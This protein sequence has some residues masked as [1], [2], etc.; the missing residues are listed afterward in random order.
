MEG[1]LWESGPQE[2]P[3]PSSQLPDCPLP[4]PVPTAQHGEHVLVESGMGGAEPGRQARQTDSPPERARCWP[5]SHLAEPLRQTAAGQAS[6]LPNE[7]HTIF[8]PIFFQ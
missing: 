4:G 2:G 3:R 7:P 1:W 5:A 8:H 6:G